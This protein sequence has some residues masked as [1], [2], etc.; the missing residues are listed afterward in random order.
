MVNLVANAR[1]DSPRTDGRSAAPRRIAVIGGGPAGVLTALHLVRDGRS[2]ITIVE[3]SVRLGAGTA[4]STPHP[5]HL[6]NVPA[7]RMSA[8]TDIPDD[9]VDWLRE[10]GS[11][12][13]FA[14]RSLYGDYLGDRL[15]RAEAGH[16]GAVTR[17][18]GVAAAVTGRTV[19]IAD[20]R[21]VEADAVVFALGLPLRTGIPGGDAIRGHRCFVAD[22]WAP[23][24]L[25]RIGRRGR[26]L[27]VGT[28]L[29]MADVAVTLA[30]RG[31]ELTAISR[32]GLLPHAH[33]EQHHP[34]MPSL[35]T[36]DLPQCS[37]LPALLPAK[38]A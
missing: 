14:P 22:P 20:G 4:F 36:T 30:E 23:H 13:K 5:H 26:V 3:R 34:P 9:F 16:P 21:T 1:T 25:A 32:R 19:E 27:L 28:G 18:C 7:A 11:E 31:V 2:E 35:L 24:A 17:I 6:L 12:A 33:S 37:G 8:F 29:T 15:A 38:P 10:R